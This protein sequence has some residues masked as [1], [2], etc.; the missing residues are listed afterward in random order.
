[1]ILNALGGKPLPV[2][3][4]GLQVRDWLYVDDHCAAHPAVLERGAPGETYNI[5]GDSERTNLE[6]V[7]THLRAA[8]SRRAPRRRQL[9]RG[10][11][12]LRRRPARP[13]PALRH[14]RRQ[15]RAASS[16]GEPAESF[17]DGI[18]RTVDWYLANRGWVADVTSGAYRDWIARQYG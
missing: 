12:H 8:R 15:D 18:A 9:L 16:A 10:A 13:R 5:G 1:M 2:Y 14:R 7:A 3:G 4:D 11:D 17:D 6:V